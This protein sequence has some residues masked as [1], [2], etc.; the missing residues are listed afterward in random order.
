[1]LAGPLILLLTLQDLEQAC[2][3]HVELELIGQLIQNAFMKRTKTNKI[4][5]H[6]WLPQQNN[7]KVMEMDALPVL[8][9]CV[10][11]KEKHGY[12]DQVWPRKRENLLFRVGVFNIGSLE[13]F[14]V[15]MNLLKSHT[16][17]CVHV[18]F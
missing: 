4:A 8:R 7:K 12:K 15:S 1:M 11:V 17:W 3:F 2:S 6:V 13:G 14:K 18:F 10:N 16:K 5:L 9:F